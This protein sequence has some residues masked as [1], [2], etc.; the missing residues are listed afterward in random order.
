M[1]NCLK[2][3]HCGV[4]GVEETVLSKDGVPTTIRRAKDWSY[5]MLPSKNDAFFL[6][7]NFWHLCPTCTGYLEVFM[8][9]RKP[10]LFTGEH[11]YAYEA[12]AT[13]EGS[14]AER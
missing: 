5:V 7:E 11:R 6:K 10:G 13:P 14:N 2:C 1:S 12:P 8:G 3:N 4:I 9:E